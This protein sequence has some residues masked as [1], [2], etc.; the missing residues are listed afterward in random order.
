MKTLNFRGK[1]G[2]F[3]ETISQFS[4]RFHPFLP[5]GVQFGE[6]LPI[7]H[8]FK[9]VYSGTS[10]NPPSAILVGILTPL[11]VKMLV[12]THIL[13]ALLTSIG[14]RIPTNLSDAEF[15][16]VPHSLNW[17]KVLTNFTIILN[18]S[19]QNDR[20]SIYVG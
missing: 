13:T 15:L 6:I 12:N 3:Y 7:S 2:H 17:A 11:I 19:V 4:V 14:E 8:L 18:L 9:S 20:I 1:S 5:H 16:E 10:K